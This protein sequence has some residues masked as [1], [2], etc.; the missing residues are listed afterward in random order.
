MPIQRKQ[1]TPEQLTA[2]AALVARARAAGAIPAHRKMEHGPD[3]RFEP[4]CLSAGGVVMTHHGAYMQPTTP[5][6]WVASARERG[7]IPVA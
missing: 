2:K 3:A 5:E 7:L 1:F 6:E 4:I